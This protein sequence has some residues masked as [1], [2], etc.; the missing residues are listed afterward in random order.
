MSRCAE[1]ESLT[2]KRKDKSELCEMSPQSLPLITLH[3]QV[4]RAYEDGS[5]EDERAEP[6]PEVN[7]FPTL[8]NN[9]QKGQ[10]ALKKE[11]SLRTKRQK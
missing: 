4:N 8:V 6:P 9:K 5:T 2:K 7:N 3:D 10:C 11:V 1:G